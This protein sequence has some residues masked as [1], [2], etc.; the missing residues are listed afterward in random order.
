MYSKGLRAPKE[1]ISTRYK[2][3]SS[4]FCREHSNITNNKMWNN[5]L[6]STSITFTFTEMDANLLKNKLMEHVFSISTHA[7]ISNWNIH[8]YIFCK[9]FGV[10][11]REQPQQRTPDLPPSLPPSDTSAGTQRVPSPAETHSQSFQPVLGLAGGTPPQ[12]GIETVSTAKCDKLTEA[13]CLGQP[14]KLFVH[15]KIHMNFKLF[16]V[17]QPLES[18]Q[19][20]WCTNLNYDMF[21]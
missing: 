12:G 7:L 19:H 2:T 5:H 4:C 8:P 20:L 10:G 14:V 17:W 15:L 21:L 16:L 18:Q 13:K 11:S 9:L 3:I 1:Q 6:S